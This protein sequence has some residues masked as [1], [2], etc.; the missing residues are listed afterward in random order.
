VDIIVI[1]L[2]SSAFICNSS[3]LMKLFSDGLVVPFP[4]I[5]TADG[6]LDKSPE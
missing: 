2:L 5:V 1:E 6:F 4:E 3:I